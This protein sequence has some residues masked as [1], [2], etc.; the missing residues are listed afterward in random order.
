[1]RKEKIITIASI[2]LLLI[3]LVGATYA[4]F[5]AQG[6]G[7][8]SRDVSVTSNTTDN[9]SF[10][11]GNDISFT[12]STTNFYRNGTNLSGNTTASAILTPNNKTNQATMNYYMYLNLTS[13]PTVYS[14]GN[15]NHDAELILQVFD[16]S[17]QLVTL[18]GLG[19]QVALGNGY[20]YDITGVTGL[21]TLLN[22]HAITANGSTTTENWSI[23]ITLVNLNLNQNDNTNKTITG[24]II[25]QKDEMSRTY[26]V[27]QD[28]SSINSKMF[29]LGGDVIDIKA[30]S[31]SLTIDNQYID[32]DYI[33]SEV[34]EQTGDEYP[35]YMWYDNGTIYWYSE[36]D[37]V[38]GNED[39]SSMFYYYMYMEN[40]DLSGINTSRSE[41]M[42]DMFSNC[43]YLAESFSINLGN[44]FNT[45]NVTDMSNMFGY[46]GAG[47]QE[48]FV[49]NLGDKFYTNNVEDMSS[50]FI[51]TGNSNGVDLNLGPH[52]VIEPSTSVN[53]MF[54]S[55]K[56]TNL[57]IPTPLDL[58]S[59]DNY[60]YLFSFVTAKSGSNIVIDLSGGNLNQSA[61]TLG[62]F[63]SYDPTG[64]TILVKSAADQAWLISQDENDPKVLN[65][66]NVVVA[67]P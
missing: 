67:T 46:L 38:Y 16:G 20:G 32:E 41:D 29:D 44:D 31:R 56:F 17:N 40:V 14:T 62:M 33:I 50:M 8:T 47:A 59:I 60:N 51:N 4:Y 58:S 23:V 55:A 2:A 61:T 7:T 6:G 54:D 27:F 30:F 48:S 52:F 37:I 1:M 39:M 34:T 13:N 49:L 11:I 25:V 57:T 36:A 63:D 66:T 26:A 15:N 65:T 35:I 10:S 43:G 9:L 24:E 3:M 42:S 19:D 12:A 28:G 5:R 64:I 22:N 45:S 18:T 21:I 53:G